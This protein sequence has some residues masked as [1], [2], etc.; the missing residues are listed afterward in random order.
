MAT[1]ASAKKVSSAS[2]KKAA[3]TD[4]AKPKGK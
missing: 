2:G 4:K 3:G 1:K